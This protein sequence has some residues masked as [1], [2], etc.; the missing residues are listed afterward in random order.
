MDSPL[1]VLPFGGEAEAFQ[2]D[3][4]ETWWDGWD[5]A[6]RA[7]KTELQGDGA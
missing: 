3:L 4:V 5:D 6:D 2:L 1:F 7:L